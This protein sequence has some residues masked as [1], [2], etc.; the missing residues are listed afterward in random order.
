LLL[1][2]LVY[3]RTAPLNGSQV[4]RMLAG[5]FGRKKDT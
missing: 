3:A 2:T 4:K 5:P 1:A